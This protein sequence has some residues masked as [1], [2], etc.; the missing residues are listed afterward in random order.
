MAAR[1]WVF[2]DTNKDP[3]VET[4]CQELNVCSAGARVLLRRGYDT[5]D[6][7]AHI[8]DPMG[9][10]LGSPAL[11]PELEDAAARV[12]RAVDAGERI[13]VHGD[14]DADGISGTALLTGAL[15]KIG[16]ICQPFVPD[17]KRDGYGVADRLI[18]HA[19]QKNV[20]LL[21]TVDTGSSAHT[22]LQAARDAGIDVIVCDHHLFDARPAGATYFL[23]PHREDSRYPNKDLCGCGVAYKLLVGIAELSDRR[24]D[25]EAELDLV[26]LALLGD[27]MPIVGENRR[28]V[29]EGLQRMEQKP[30]PG[31]LALLEVSRLAGIRLA[32]E[33]LGFQLAPRINAAGRIE[34]ARTALD[35]LLTD[36]MQEAR[37]LAWKLD[38]L[39]RR[40]REIDERITAEA[41]R[42]AEL[43]ERDRQPA[44]LVLASERWE[45]GVVGISAARVARRFERPTIVLSIDGDVATGS[46]RSVEGFDLKAALDR[47][48]EHLSRYGGHAAAAG[49]ALPVTKLDDFRAAFERAVALDP[50]AAP[51][52]EMNIDAEIGLAELDEGLIEF[53]DRFGPYAQGHP[54]PIFASRAIALTGPP[55]V[56]GGRHLK[57]HAGAAQ[58]ERSFIGFGMAEAHASSLQMTPS[59]DLAYR[60]RYREGSSFDPWELSLADLRVADPP[61]MASDRAEA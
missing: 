60:I 3:R 57:L 4:L 45:L 2:P 37:S 52:R 14:Y 18:A 32:A 24:V 43:L 42:D 54:A 27:Q 55:R 61:V 38:E 41:G 59:L 50:P 58:T 28:L 10:A 35:L 40:R 56:V 15:R 31:M 7:A 22:Q 36:D 21:I 9:E 8:L 13:V 17:R 48:A 46:A 12:L 26:A 11:I 19:A 6:A 51:R 29:R 20:T 5:V 53:L 39:N 44:A 30:R 23:N 1:Q 47:C 16:G 33:D 25:F 49:M 34:S